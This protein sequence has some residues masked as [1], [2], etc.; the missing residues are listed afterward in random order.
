[1]NALNAIAI[2][3]P[4]ITV[5]FGILLNRQDAS[6]IRMEM[7]SEI[8]QLRS[9]MKVEIGQLRAGMIQL[10]NTIHADMIGIHE[11]LATVEAKQNG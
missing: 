8:G 4:T 5:L 11:R 3:I 2:A 1:M 7:K 9:E 10:R 6:S